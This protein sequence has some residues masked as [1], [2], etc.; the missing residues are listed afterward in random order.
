[1]V[2]IFDI[3]KLISIKLIIKFDGRPLETFTIVTE[4]IFLHV[5]FPCT[6]N[7]NQQTLPYSAG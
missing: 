4:I 1:M 2:T 7:N 6:V 3:F 5:A